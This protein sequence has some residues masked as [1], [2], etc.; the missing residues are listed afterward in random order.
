MGSLWI[1]KRGGNNM[2]IQMNVNVVE[3]KSLND[4]FEIDEKVL[5]S[6]DIVS[7]RVI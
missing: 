7:S 2:E 1:N 3:K 6:K 5:L 4:E